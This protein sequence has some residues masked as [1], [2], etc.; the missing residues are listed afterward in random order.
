[1]SGHCAGVQQKICEVV[2]LAIYVHCY[3]HYL[4]LRQTKKGRVFLPQRQAKTHK[5]KPE[6]TKKHK[7]T[8]N[9]LNKDTTTH[10]CNRRC[11]HTIVTLH[12]QHVSEAVF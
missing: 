9:L 6:G 3:A 12:L 8:E 11:C 1:M 5:N 2:P 7:D 4:N 10:L